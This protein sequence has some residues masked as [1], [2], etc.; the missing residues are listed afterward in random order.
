MSSESVLDVPFQEH[1][2]ISVE[3]AMYLC[4]AGISYQRRMKI[5]HNYHNT[6]TVASFDHYIQYTYDYVFEVLPYSRF[7]GVTILVSNT[8][9]KGIPYTTS[10]SSTSALKR[11]LHFHMELHGPVHHDD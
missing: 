11:R 9:R 3:H 10:L 8:D 5:C 2:S 6:T 4:S 1:S 7:A